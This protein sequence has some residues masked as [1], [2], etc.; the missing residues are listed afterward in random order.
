MA[1]AY[2]YASAHDRINEGCR[3][4][5]RDSTLIRDGAR[6]ISVTVGAHS[7]K[8]TLGGGFDNAYLKRPCC[9]GCSAIIN[10]G[11]STAAASPLWWRGGS[12][13]EAAINAVVPLDRVRFFPGVTLSATLAAILTVV[14][15]V[16]CGAHD[17]A[18]VAKAEVAAVEKTG[19]KADAVAVEVAAVSSAAV[20]AWG[21][22]SPMKVCPP[23]PLLRPMLVSKRCR[24][25]G[26]RATAD[27]GHL[28]AAAGVWRVDAVL[29]VAVAVAVAEVEEQADAEYAD[30][31]AEGGNAVEAGGGVAVAV[32]AAVALPHEAPQSLPK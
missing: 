20:A 4:L 1:S 17:D 11:A 14:W 10:T 27:A 12:G 19:I 26:S 13:T 2:V 5:V 22:G 21:S 29:V 9:A 16:S 18:D 24:R 30:G 25:E 28:A 23:S 32:V 3:L 7:D 8:D 31:E 15:N 6:H